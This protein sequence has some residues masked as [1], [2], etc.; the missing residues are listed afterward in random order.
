M[1]DLVDEGVE[2][3]RISVGELRADKS[4]VLVDQISTLIYD[5]FREPPWSEDLEKPRILF[6]LGVELM[7]RNAV[8]LIARVKGPDAIIGYIL[9]HEALRESEDP[10][11]LTLS[12]IAGAHA[13]DYLC[14]GGKR[15]FYGDGLGISPRFR[16]QHIAERLFVALNRVLRKAG[17]A[18]CLG[19]TDLTAQAPR[20]LLSKLGFQ[21]LPIYDALYLQR[22]YWLL[23]L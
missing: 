8:L 5:V 11:D 13:L 3:T 12:R 20:G 4:G 19:R 18:Y 9:G 1:P 15:V 23:Q 7:R 6:G 2:I 14:E 22:T 17:F 21:E 16:R 10:R